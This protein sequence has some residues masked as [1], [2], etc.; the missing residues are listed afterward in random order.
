MIKA[1]QH[2]SYMKVC[3]NNSNEYCGVFKGYLDKFVLMVVKQSILKE[4]AGNSSES[5]WLTPTVFNV[6]P[7]SLPPNIV[8]CLTETNTHL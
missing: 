8:G 5:L 7:T 6:L 4:D 2:D 3:R 1:L